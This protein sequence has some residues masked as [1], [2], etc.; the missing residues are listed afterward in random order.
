MYDRHTNPFNKNLSNRTF[1]FDKICI[2]Y[3][4]SKINY[5][6]KPGYQV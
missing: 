2:D 3:I 1:D 5:R 4:N 6:I